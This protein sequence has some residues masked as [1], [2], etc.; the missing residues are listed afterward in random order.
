MPTPSFKG[1]SAQQWPESASVRYNPP[2][3][4]GIKTVALLTRYILRQ[5]WVPA[6]LAVLVIGFMVIAGA[7]QEQIKLVTD[8]L[9]IVQIGFGD[10]SWMAI[11]AFPTLVGYI[12]PITF[13]L[14]IMMTF[15]RMAQQNEITALKAAG[16]PLKRVVLPVLVAGAVLSG[17]CFWAQDQGQPWA[18]ARMKHLV[19]G[20]L[21]LRVTID[22][23]PAGVMHEYGDWRIFVGKNDGGG[24][25]GDIVVLQPQ[26]DGQATSFYAESASLERAGGRTALVMHKGLYLKPSKEGEKL[27]RVPFDTLTKPV[28]Q[29]DSL[30]KSGARQGLTLRQL[31]GEEQEAA[32]LFK[33]T[34]SIPVAVELRKLRI[35]I[36]ERLSFPL[37]C[38]AVAFVA[39]PIGARTKR[40]GRSYTFAAGFL[41]VGVYFVLRK[42]LEPPGLPPLW[43]AVALGQL[44]NLLLCAAG[45]VLVLRVDRI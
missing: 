34:K 37:M 38:L 45:S 40:A 9:P 4:G 3:D 24:R 12:F 20:E 23:L 36:S 17:V 15:G 22:M 1:T 6:L 30:E 16:I 18:Y 21:P 11:Y 10:I 32:A 28:P 14:G 19:T 31:L 41:I 29:L 33:E 43:A 39:A 25:L 26:A 8:K 27:T 7:V 2:L 35:E 44:P 13:L 5:I 42:T